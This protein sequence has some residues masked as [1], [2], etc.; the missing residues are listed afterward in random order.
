MCSLQIPAANIDRALLK[1]M[2][3]QAKFL[4]FGESD[5]FEHKGQSDNLA[6]YYLIQEENKMMYFTPHPNLHHLASLC[7]RNV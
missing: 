1:V 6:G 4:L 3:K 2:K 5:G 7:F